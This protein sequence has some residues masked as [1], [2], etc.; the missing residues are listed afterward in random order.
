M[1]ISNK[2]MEVVIVPSEHL[3]HDYPTLASAL[4]YS[5]K[6]LRYSQQGTTILRI[7]NSPTFPGSLNEDI[8]SA[9]LLRHESEEGQHANIRGIILEKK[10]G[11]DTVYKLYSQTEFMVVDTGKTVYDLSFNPPLFKK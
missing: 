10:S 3:N 4:E 8:T 6:E 1:D 2:V 7:V 11:K 9:L 5:E